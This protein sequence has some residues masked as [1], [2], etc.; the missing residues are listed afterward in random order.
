MAYKTPHR[1]KIEGWLQDPS[2]DDCLTLTYSTPTELSK[3]FNT[4]NQ[5]MRHS[6]P[7]SSVVKD[8]VACTVTI[9]RSGILPPTAPKKPQPPRAPIGGY[10][11]NKDGSRLV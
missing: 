11:R 9:Q 8:P 2:A 1:L 10:K 5:L 3:Y 7:I 6:Y 4:A